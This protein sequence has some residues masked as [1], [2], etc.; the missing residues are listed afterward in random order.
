R[1]I[2]TTAPYLT[3]AN[4]RAPHGLTEHVPPG[5]RAK[6]VER[7]AVQGE[8]DPLREGKQD[9]SDAGPSKRS[10]MEVAP[11]MPPGSAAAEAGSSD[12]RTGTDGGAGSS[13][14]RPV[15]KRRKRVRFAEPS[16]QEAPVVSTGLPWY[17]PEQT[18]VTGQELLASYADHADRLLDR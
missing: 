7:R 3:S 12:P 2:M 14:E 11:Q 8:Q 13:A 16:D 4:V 10:R 6:P 17:G 9:P 5:K 1:G 18:E 15:R